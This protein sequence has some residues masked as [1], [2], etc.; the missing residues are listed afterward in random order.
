MEALVRVRKI[1][2]D[3]NNLE[4]NKKKLRE[5]E[6]KLMQLYK[7]KEEYWKQ[8]VGMAWFKDGDKNTKFF[9]SY[10]KR[11]KRK[12]RI[13]EIKNDQDFMLRDSQEIGEEAIR[14]FTDQFS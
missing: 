3:L 9:H 12:L 11:R 4:C 14:V 2:L 6:N 10:V 8:K 5:A 13:N 1:Q 7:V